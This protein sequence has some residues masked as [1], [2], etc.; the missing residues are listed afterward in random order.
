MWCA[1]MSSG[2]LWG[3][4][5]WCGWLRDVMW[6]D[7]MWCRK[8]VSYHSTQ[9]TTKYWSILIN[10]WDTKHNGTKTLMFDS[11]ITWD[12]QYIARSNLGHA[13][14]NGT[15]TFMF[16]SRNACNVIYI[17]WWD[18]KRNVTIAPAKKSGTPTNTSKHSSVKT[19]SS[20][21]MAPENVM[22]RVKSRDRKRSASIAPA[23]KL[24]KHQQNMKWKAQWK[25]CN[26]TWPKTMIPNARRDRITTTLPDQTSQITVQAAILYACST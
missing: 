6:C 18:S 22:S 21:A 7:A 2:W 10:L 19:P 12:V 3:E 11:R 17:A 9:G 13:K 24:T 8:N 14:H 26:Q 4:V 16:D 23:T 1:V 25:G 20:R 5:R 15:T